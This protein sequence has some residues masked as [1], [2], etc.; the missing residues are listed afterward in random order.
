MYKTIESKKKWHWPLRCMYTVIS[1]EAQ[2]LFPLNIT[3]NTMNVEFYYLNANWTNIPYA[4]LHAVILYDCTAITEKWI[5]TLRNVELSI[6]STYEKKEDGSQHTPDQSDKCT[7]RES[8]QTLAVIQ[9]FMRHSYGKFI[10]D[11]SIWVG[12]AVKGA[13]VDCRHDSTKFWN[14]STIYRDLYLI[15]L[16]FHQFNGMK[17]NI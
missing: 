16:W 7:S 3:W 11:L 12:R 13:F 14:Y 9:F 15:R 17:K 2:L 10:V 8:R 1:I 4:W 5:F 6:V